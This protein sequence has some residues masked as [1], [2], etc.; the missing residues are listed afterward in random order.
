VKI[1]IPD[2]ARIIMDTL[3]NNGFK[4]YIVGG[5]VR[6]SLVGKSP[7]D[8]DICTNATPE[9]MIMAFHN[10]HIIPTGIKH[11]T[12]TVM[13]NDV[14]YEVTTF[15][16]DGNYSDSRRPDNVKF[17]DNIV[18]DLSRRDFTINAMA[19]NEKDGLFDPY[20]GY[21]DLLI[22][23]VIRCV[24]N[25]DDRFTEDPLRMLR[26]IRFSAQLGFDIDNRTRQ[27]I[28]ANANKIEKISNERI[29]DEICKILMSDNP[30]NIEKLQ[31]TGLMRYIIPKL[32]LCFGF[33]QNNDYHNLNV[34]EHIIKSLID[35]PK[36]LN[37]RLAL[38]LHDIGKLKCKTIGQDVQGHFYNHEKVSM[39]MAKVWLQKYR[40]D[41]D[42]IDEV[43][44]LILYH[45]YFTEYSKHSIKKLLNIVGVDIALKLVEIRNQDIKAQNEKYLYRLGESKKIKDIINEIILAN[46]AFSIKDL[47]ING[48]DLIIMGFEEGEKIGKILNYLLN[49][50]LEFPEYNNRDK[51]IEIVENDFK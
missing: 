6:D 25:P 47:A 9:E 39:Q 31:N 43:C 49:L 37:I 26:A 34:G 35:S 33:K 46:E 30:Q 12:I 14:G 3:S 19:Y 2:D 29:R 18:D 51:L 27:G 23:N 45:D 1:F 16:I 32:K 50:V 44:T 48:D 24:R 41:N 36:D 38:L 20:D 15:R 13:H 22:R 10:F 42:T 28:I 17:V 8:Y 11:G 40:F 21:S 7:K 4:S 5:S